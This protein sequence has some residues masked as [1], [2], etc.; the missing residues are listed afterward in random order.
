MTKGRRDHDKEMKR[1]EEAFVLD[2]LARSD[3]EIM[4]E[5]AR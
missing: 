2:I 1:V 3:S 5:A 4:A